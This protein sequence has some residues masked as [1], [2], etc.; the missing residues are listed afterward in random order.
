MASAQ[1]TR[2]MIEV[3]NIAGTE[4]FGCFNNMKAA[5]STLNSLALSKELGEYPAVLVYAYKNGKP[6]REY[7]ATYSGNKWRVPKLPKEQ[8]PAKTSH[9]KVHR[10][11]R[12][13]KEYD[14]PEHCFREG[15]PD[16]MNR[17][18][19]VPACKQQGMDVRR[20][21]HALNW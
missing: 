12:L 17:S 10:K 2:K 11:R 18:Y 14:S 15:F 16:W 19:P 4:S 5:N 21:V 6:T 7:V 3:M 9:K 8:A 13:C 1:T 20:R